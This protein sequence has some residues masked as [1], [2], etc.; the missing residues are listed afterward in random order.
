MLIM[1]SHLYYNLFNKREGGFEKV[2]NIVVI[3]EVPKFPIKND[4]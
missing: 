4:I 1:I 2:L 3:E